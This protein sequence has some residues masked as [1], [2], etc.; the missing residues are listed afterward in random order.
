MDRLTFDTETFLIRPGR[1]AP[2]LVCAT[3]PDRG[4][5]H[6]HFDAAKIERWLGDALE[7][8]N[9]LIVG[10]NI[11]FD[12]G[13]MAARFP[14]LLPAIWAAYDADRITDTMI[15]QALLDTASGHFRTQKRSLADCARRHGLA[16]LDKGADSW[17]LR[18][19]E[20]IG[21]PLAQWPE[22]A[23][24]Y[25]IEDAV[26][27]D[28]IFE[29]QEPY[30]HFLDDQFRQ[31]RAYW[32]LGLCATWGLRTSPE[33]VKQL[34][35][36]TLREVARLTEI[37]EENRDPELGDPN[38]DFRF[39]LKAKD[40][41]VKSGKN[42]GAKKFGGRITANAKRRMRV[43]CEDMKIDL[44]ETKTGDVSLS[45][46]ACEDTRDPILLAYA[47][48]D[49]FKRTASKDLPLLASG[50][51]KPVHTRF[52]IAETW[53]VTSSKPALQNL[54]SLPG[55]RECFT[56]RPGKVF[57]Q[58]D[59]DG[60]ELRTFAQFCI[61]TLGFSALGDALNAGIDVHT[62]MA[63][64]IMGEPY[65]WCKAHIKTKEVQHSRKLG[66]IL[67]FGVPGG[68]GLKAIVSYAWVNFGI[69]LT[70]GEA[71]RLKSQYFKV[72]PEAR[73]YFKWIEM[74]NQGDR[75]YVV[76]QLFSNRV[77]SN[78]RFP[79]ACN[80]T[81]QGLGADA[82]K[83][84]FYLIQRACY[85]EPESPL[86]G[87]RMSVQV[88]DENIGETDE[89]TCHEAATEM[90]RLMIAGANEFLPDVPATTDPVVM[91][92]WSK[93]AHA[94]YDENNRLIPWSLASCLC[95]NCMKVKEKEKAKHAEYTI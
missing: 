43:V 87:S 86:F 33:G 31:A 52:G 66:K 70:V 90:V 60:L 69:R 20:L 71:Q 81:F 48:Y 40:T 21:V 78:M 94:V 1:N 63:A 64:E 85:N 30:T 61:S 8:K 47:T 35:A 27:T 26:T 25:A 68:L 65:D 9:T 45:A 84:G 46:E 4:I 22:A 37:L 5:M 41:I 57:I 88:H 56:P 51:R 67:N 53:R 3:T 38:D 74:Q 24:H 42:K 15:R 34:T 72:V 44:K 36:A 29:L 76:V 82:A 77:R 19:R 80:T 95:E 11:A 62:L 50:T 32:A 55:V 83:R 7:N 58:A 10:H 92:Y 14:D 73:E 49:Q 12:M 54:P 89:A 16:E 23:L 39:P 93:L 75:G 2:E 28:R 79:V 13:V 18:Y 91:R 17:R 6:G 59:Y